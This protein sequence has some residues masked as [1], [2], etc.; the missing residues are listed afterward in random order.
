MFNSLV[1]PIL[2]YGSCVWDPHLVT[3]TQKLEKH[4]TRFVTENHIFEHGNSK[5]NM[6]ILGWYQALQERRAKLKLI[7]FY[8]IKFST[9]TSVSPTNPDYSPRRPFSF[10][11][12]RSMKE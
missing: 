2:D 10:L 6:D 5:M 3:Q 11:G 12:P 8:S 4:A 9:T 1:R 7:L